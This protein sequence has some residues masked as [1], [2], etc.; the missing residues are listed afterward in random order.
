M[1]VVVVITVAVDNVE[2]AET[3]WSD[4]VI[5]EAEAEGAGAVVPAATEADPIYTPYYTLFSYS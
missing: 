3:S 1:A 5:A 4:K 2:E